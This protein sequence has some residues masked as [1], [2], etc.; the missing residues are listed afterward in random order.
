VA[1]LKLFLE[2][3]AKSLEA[4]GLTAEDSLAT[5]RLLTLATLAATRRELSLDHVAEAIE[6]S[7]VQRCPIVAGDDPIV[8]IPRF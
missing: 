6:V 4:L 1:D 2:T 7:V 5:M 8:R 3:D